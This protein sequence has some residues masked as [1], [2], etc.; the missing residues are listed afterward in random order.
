MGRGGDGMGR[1]RWYGEEE[2]FSPSTYG[3][4]QHVVS[5]VMYN[6]CGLVRDCSH[7]I[8]LWGSHDSPF[9]N[10]MAGVA[11]TVNYLPLLRGRLFSIKRYLLWGHSPRIMQHTQY[12]EVWGPDISNLGT[13]LTQN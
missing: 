13:N 12:A 1:R 2:L 11:N 9:F 5:M 6:M 7:K 4:V 8:Y 10:H 3:Y